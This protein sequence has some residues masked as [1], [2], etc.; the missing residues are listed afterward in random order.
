MTRTSDGGIMLPLAQ[1]MEADIDAIHRGTAIYTAIPE[2]DALLDGMGWPAG[3]RRLLDPGAG[4]GGMLVA[5]LARLEL[6]IDDIEHATHRVHGY[7][8][9]EGAA[10]AARRSV[11]GHLLLRG[12]SEDAADTAAD[13]I[14][15]RKDFLL[16]SVPTARYDMIVGN[17]PYFRLLNLPADYRC[18]FMTQVPRHAHADMMHAYLQKAADIL[19][20]GGTIGQ[21]TADRWLVNA[22]AARLRES[23]G[24]RLRV[25]RADRLEAQ[26][27]FYRPKSRR[28]GTPARVHPIR[29]ILSEAQDG[30]PLSA[31]PFRIDAVPA[32]EGVPFSSLVTIRLAPW[33]GPEGIFVVRTTDGLPA[34][35]MVPCLEPED[36]KGG[37]ATPTRWAIATGTDRPEE[38]VVRH[39][40]NAMTAM[41][42]RGLRRTPWLPPE[43]FEGKLPLKCDAVLVPRIS[44][45][46]RGVLLPAG[47]MG[48]NHN[49]VIVSGLPPERILAMLDDPQVQAQADALAPR[50]ENGYRSYTTTL[51]R[52]LIIPYSHLKEEAP[53]SKAA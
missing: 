26:S 10:M 30:R 3:G 33:L 36:L 4:N 17:P 24:R 46:L 21:I 11:K 49:I 6:A 43:S 25:A 31:E 20:P 15:E 41:P 40:E 51:L 13:E 32:V 16:D 53:C 9:H 22:G 18:T 7:E 2:I 1:G 27:A 50:I 23:L 12:W 5:A 19:A 42:P 38:A 39:L 8:F 47:M 34:H 44:Q 28:K 37:M 14:V 45:R 52:Q 48:I 29:I 35:R